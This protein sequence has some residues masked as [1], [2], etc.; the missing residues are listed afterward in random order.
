MKKI[1]Y[2]LAFT[3]VLASCKSGSAASSRISSNSL[4]DKIVNS[5]SKHIGAPYKTAGKT[6]SGYDCSGL[7]YSTFGEFDI[8]LPRTSYSQ[9]KTGKS[10]GQNSNKAAKGDL[11]FFKTNNSSRVNHVGIVTD[12]TNDEIKFIHASTSRGVII[13]STKESYYEKSFTQVNRILE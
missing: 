1:L 13:S 5:A 9:S 7:V 8:Q 6:P 12:A 11:I 3:V 10:L 4:A 2:L